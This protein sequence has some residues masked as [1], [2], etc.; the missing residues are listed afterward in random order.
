MDILLNIR[1]KLVTE[2]I[3]CCEM[4]RIYPALLRKDKS[5]KPLPVGKLAEILALYNAEN[6]REREG[7]T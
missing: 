6:P 4:L 1:L 7:M 2:G 3:L 5:F